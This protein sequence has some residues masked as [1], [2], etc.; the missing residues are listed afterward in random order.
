MALYDT[1]FS[2]YMRLIVSYDHKRQT[3]LHLVNYWLEIYYR[4]QFLTK[5]RLTS[6]NL[7]K[8]SKFSLMRSYTA[9]GCMAVT[10]ALLNGA[11]D[12]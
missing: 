6:N 12:T 2:A 7:T 11:T 3:L 4:Y 5:K 1:V 9:V 10:K 8:F